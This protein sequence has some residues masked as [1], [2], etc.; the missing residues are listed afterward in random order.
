MCCKN[1]SDH[2]S[3]GV[4]VDNYLFS[5][6]DLEQNILPCLCVPMSKRSL[7]KCP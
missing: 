3:F 5:H 4:A 7:K 2:V 6:E 1:I